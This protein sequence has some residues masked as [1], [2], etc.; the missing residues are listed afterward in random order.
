M[1]TRSAEN[2]WK[3]MKKKSYDIKNPTNKMNF[4]KVEISII[5]K[6]EKGERKVQNKEKLWREESKKEN[7]RKEGWKRAKEG[8]KRAKEEIK[9]N[10]RKKEI[11]GKGI[12]EEKKE[13]HNEVSLSKRKMGI[14]KEAFESN[15]LQ[16]IQKI[17]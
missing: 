12:V 1:K 16:D 11:E 13:G 6:E 14:Y 7:K 2:N 17:K 4:E 15:K 10:L 3:D 5:G 9:K 8:R